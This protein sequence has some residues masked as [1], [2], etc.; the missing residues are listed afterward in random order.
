MA[1][2]LRY[3]EI[4][5]DE[6]DMMAVGSVQQ[7]HKAACSPLSKPGSRERSGCAQL[8]FFPMTLPHAQPGTTAHPLGPL[9]LEFIVLPQSALPGNALTDRAT[10]VPQDGLAVSSSSRVDGEDE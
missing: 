8:A 9:T 10:E 7:G 2:I 4:C 1:H 6:K 3:Y 5:H